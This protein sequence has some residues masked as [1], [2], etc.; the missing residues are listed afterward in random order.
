MSQSEFGLGITH[1]MPPLRKKLYRCVF[2]IC[3]RY[4]Y[5]LSTSNS[6]NLP[7]MFIGLNPSTADEYKLDPTLTR[8]KEFVRRWSY[9]GFVMT[10]LFAFRA[11]DP[12]EM[13]KQS[14]PVGPGNDAAILDVA[15]KAAVIVCA[16]GNGGTLLNRDAHV[17]QLLR[18]HVPHKPLMSFGLTSQGH[19]LHPLARGKSFIPYDRKLIRLI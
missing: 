1:K 5:T 18:K 2:S 16:W 17:K 11:T 6:S 8:L 7:V 4:R 3:T 15:Q 12:K 10:N 13:M 14:D 9:D 19:P